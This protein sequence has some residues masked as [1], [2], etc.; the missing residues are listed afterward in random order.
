MITKYETFEQFVNDSNN[1]DSVKIYYCGNINK[2]LFISLVDNNNVVGG[3]YCGSPPTGE[4]HLAV[5]KVG[6]SDEFKGKGY[7][8][9]LYIATL[10]LVGDTGISPHRRKGSSRLDS[11]NVWKR[12]SEKGYIKR[13]DLEKKLYDNNPLLDSKYVLIDENLK[14]KTLQRIKK[15]SDNAWDENEINKKAWEIVNKH[16]AIDI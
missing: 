12:L 6:I 11:Q 13:V 7:G 3:L 10:S 14:N 1:L 15:L 8:S 5:M 16:M 4:K 2:E 9:L